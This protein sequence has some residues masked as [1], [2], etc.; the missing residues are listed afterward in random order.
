MKFFTL[1]SFSP[2]YTSFFF[3]ISFLFEF[4]NDSNNANANDNFAW[5]L[6]RSIYF[7]TRLNFLYL[8][9]LFLEFFDENDINSLIYL[10]KN[11]LAFSWTS[12]NYLCAKCFYSL[13]ILCK[14]MWMDYNCH[15]QLCTNGSKCKLQFDW[16]SPHSN[17]N[18][19]GNW[20]IWYP[21]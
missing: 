10:P 6:K 7:G 12:N 11:I 18:E 1:K 19:Q 15:F 17:I 3:S 9:I 4:I 5:Y 16:L 8:A 20:I 14:N 2:Y 13:D 21:S